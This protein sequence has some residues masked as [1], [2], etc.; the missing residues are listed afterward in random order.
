MKTLLLIRHAEAESTY[1]GVDDRR[2]ELT[3]EGFTQAVHLGKKIASGN[4]QPE[5]MFY[6][7]AVRTTVTTQLILEQLDMPQEAI[8]VEPS[9][10]EANVGRLLDFINQRADQADSLAIVGHNPAIS[11]LAEYLTG[12][13]IGNLSPADAVVITFDLESWEL[14]SQATGSLL[15]RL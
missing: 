6:S 1:F 7:D 2:R 4:F 12:D 5:V 8:F 9:F 13:V 14:V 15:T 11:F 3:Q 10:Y